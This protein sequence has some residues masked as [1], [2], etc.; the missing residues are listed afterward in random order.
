[1]KKYLILFLSFAIACA[2]HT[3]DCSFSHYDLDKN[4]YNVKGCMLDSLEHGDWYYYD[5]LNRLSESGRYDHGVREGAWHYSNQNTDS[6][7]FWTVYRNDRLG[8]RTNIPNMLRLSIDSAFYVK[9]Q[10]IDSNRYLNLVITV[11]NPLAKE[12]K[13]DSFYKRNEQEILDRG[14][15]FTYSHNKLI[16][17]KKKYFSNWYSLSRNG[18]PKLE[19]LTFYGYLGDQFIEV[20]CTYDP[21]E[22]AFAST[23]FTAVALNL[24]LETNRFINPFDKL[25]RQKY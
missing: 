20:T 7:I 15:N 10:A 12:V 25:E 3:Q 1:M 21:K 18:D 5:S 17:K 24:F 2:D 19:I 4:V 13:L 6:M 8:L 16:S 22:K 9:F 11:N 14:Y 23:I